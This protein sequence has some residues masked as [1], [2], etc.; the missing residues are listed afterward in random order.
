MKYVL[1]IILLTSAIYSS[2][3]QTRTIEF[4]LTHRI[5]CGAEKMSKDEAVKLDVNLSDD[6]I[7]YGEN[8]FH[9]IAICENR[10]WV[11]VEVT[12]QPAD[13]DFNFH[14]TQYIA[15]GGDAGLGIGETGCS[16]TDLAQIPNCWMR[17]TEIT[18]PDLKFIQSSISIKPLQKSSQIGSKFL[19]RRSQ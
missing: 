4:K 2:A 10:F 1:S 18:K 16:T 9:E 13:T 11:K 15:V 3:N 5:F 19:N 14:L 6:G 17:R 8:N 7:V 12:K